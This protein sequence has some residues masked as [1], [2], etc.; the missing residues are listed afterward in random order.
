MSTAA[1]NGH[2]TEQAAI[3]ASSIVAGIPKGDLD[4]IAAALAIPR[5]AFIRRD[6]RQ[7]VDAA[8]RLVDAG[9][10]VDAVGLMLEGISPDTASTLAEPRSSLAPKRDAQILRENHE[11]EIFRAQIKLL[12]NSEPRDAA[13][14]IENL[15]PHGESRKA[16]DVSKW[17]APAPYREFIFQNLMPRGVLCLVIAQGGSGKSWLT[18]LLTVSLSTGRALL[19]NFEPACAGRVLWFSSEDDNDELHRRFQHLQAQYNLTD[20]QTKLFVKNL[21]VYPA[22]AFA[23][24]DADGNP[25]QEL[26]KLRAEI[27]EFNPDLIVLDPLAHFFAGD[28]NAN[29]AVAAWCNAVLDAA[30]LSS[31]R[32]SVL[33]AHHTSKAAQAVSD[34]AS[35]RGASSLRDS[36][37]N[38]LNLTPLS[39]DEIQKFGIS[40]GARFIKCEI[41]KANYSAKPPKPSYFQRMDGG[42]LVDFDAE[43]AAKEIGAA[44]VE[45]VARVL[46]DVIGANPANLSAREI[47]HEASGKEL[48]HMVLDIIG[49]TVS[50]ATFSDAAK[51]AVCV[52]FLDVDQVR[53]EGSCKPKLVPRAVTGNRQE[54]DEEGVPF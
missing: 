53:V 39:A 13:R 22:T 46:A 51:H 38:V 36:A 31:V 35:A 2:V 21:R 50:R 47:S 20:E 30:R 17:I 16:A 48:R 40:D 42:V 14:I 37:R 11:R 33:V 25:T 43:A 27:R 8:A 23:L 54:T 44:S 18:L 9:A 24:I 28:E 4:C 1:H 45:R 10:V 34:S 7:L 6:H 26:Q 52:G 5:E 19:K 12:E 49:A 3:A 32:A 15:I 41:T 29:P